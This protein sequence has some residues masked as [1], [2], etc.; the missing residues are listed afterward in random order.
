MLRYRASPP[1]NI[2]RYGDRAHGQSV[3]YTRIIYRDHEQIGVWED[4]A[5]CWKEDWSRIRAGRFSISPD[6]RVN[7]Q[8]LQ[9]E[10]VQT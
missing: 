4:Y 6:G 8:L 7:A 1:H 3:Y 5:K 10:E 9:L 2:R